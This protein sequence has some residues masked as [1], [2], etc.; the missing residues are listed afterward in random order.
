[1][2]IYHAIVDLNILPQTY[3]RKIQLYHVFISILEEAFR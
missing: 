3:S 2:K 1:M